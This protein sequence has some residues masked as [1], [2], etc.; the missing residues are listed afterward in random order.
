MAREEHKVDG[1]TKFGFGIGG[2]M[3][4][5]TAVYGICYATYYTSALLG[6]AVQD[7]IDR[8][9]H[10]DTLN[11]TLYGSI[12]LLT[13]LLASSI[14]RKT[15]HKFEPIPRKSDMT[16]QDRGDDHMWF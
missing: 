8:W 12:A 2:L 7:R 3:L 14:T 11:A 6:M 15:T 4:G 1:L 9:D 10:W 5:G 13:L 16:E